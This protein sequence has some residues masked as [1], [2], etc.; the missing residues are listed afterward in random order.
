Y[1]RVYEGRVAP[2]ELAGKIVIVGPTAA[3]LQDQ[4]QT[5]TSGREPMSGPEVLANATATVLDGVPL[6]TAPGWVNIALI[7]LLGCAAAR[8]SATARCCSATCAA[9]LPSPRLSR[10]RG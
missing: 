3:S 10:L 7:V 1:S 4:H 6:H 8:S 9:L 5:P 2:S